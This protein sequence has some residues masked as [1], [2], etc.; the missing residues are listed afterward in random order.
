M[1]CRRE[2]TDLQ[3]GMNFRLEGKHSVILMP[4]RPYVPCKDE[5]KEDGA[6][7]IYECHD[8][9]KTR[10]VTNRLVNRFWKPLF[11]EVMV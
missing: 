2:G 3:K 7:L 9:S 6:V 10:G 4:V 5:V 1:M 8:A 11:F